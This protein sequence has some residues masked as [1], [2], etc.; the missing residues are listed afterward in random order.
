LILI[1]LIVMYFSGGKTG[2]LEREIQGLRS[3]V[4]DLKKAVEGQSGEIRQL[5]DRLPPPKA[6]E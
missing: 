1:A 2:D 4:G 6:Q 3:E 5:R